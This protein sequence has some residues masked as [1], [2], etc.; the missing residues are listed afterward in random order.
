MGDSKVIKKGKIHEVNIYCH[1]TIYHKNRI[2]KSPQIESYFSK[3]FQSE[4]IVEMGFIGKSLSWWI[5][6][7]DMF[8]SVN[9]LF[10]KN[11]TIYKI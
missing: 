5:K 3:F 6:A 1:D 11:K 8:E 10:Y 9:K 7:K 2:D 4:N